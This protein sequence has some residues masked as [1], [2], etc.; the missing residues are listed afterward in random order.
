MSLGET[1]G[2]LCQATY[3]QGIGNDASVALNDLFPQNCCIQDGGKDTENRGH[4]R[5]SNIVSFLVQSCRSSRKQ[6]AGEILQFNCN[7]NDQKATE[8]NTFFPLNDF[9]PK[10][11]ILLAL[12]S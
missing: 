12:R 5:E 8:L 6:C 7:S 9:N 3:I 4:H 1:V 2:D 10:T 11:C